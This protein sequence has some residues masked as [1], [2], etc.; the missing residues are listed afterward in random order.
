MIS[1]WNMYDSLSEGN[2]KKTKRTA[3]TINTCFVV[4]LI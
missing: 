4:L 3:V 1:D 2:K